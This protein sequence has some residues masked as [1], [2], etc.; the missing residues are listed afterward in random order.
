MVLLA[1]TLG[2]NGMLAPH[3]D[4]SVGYDLPHLKHFSNF[5]KDEPTTVMILSISHLA[6]KCLSERSRIQMHSGTLR[7]EPYSSLLSSKN[8]IS[9]YDIF[10]YSLIA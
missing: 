5:P 10:P 4:V 6:L 8:V 7:K 9:G 3:W 2:N 1:E